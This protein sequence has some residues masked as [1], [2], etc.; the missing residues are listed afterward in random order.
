MKIILSLAIILLSLGCSRSVSDISKNIRY[1]GILN[2]ECELLHDGAIVDYSD[3]SND[4]PILIPKRDPLA[5]QHPGIYTF[6]TTVKKGTRIEIEKFV[7]ITSG[8]PPK[9]SSFNHA[10]GRIISESDV[11]WRDRKIQADDILSYMEHFTIFNQTFC[12]PIGDAAQTE[13]QL[14]EKV[15]SSVTGDDKTAKQVDALLI[16]AKQII[17]TS[18]SSNSNVA[19]IYETIGDLFSLR[20]MEMDRERAVKYWSEALAIYE[21]VLKEE[22]PQLSRALHRFASKTCRES[23]NK[24]QKALE[25]AL[26]LTERREGKS[27]KE[28][29]PLLESIID[30]SATRPTDKKSLELEPPY[31]FIP[32]QETFPQLR[33]LM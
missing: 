28:L 26:H 16:Q 31:F 11:S 15:T 21:R 12:N 9:T 3:G 14:M 30:C 1:S 7:H 32:P 20:H 23:N 2:K 25:R 6:R 33:R 22:D 19:E 18:G 24:S 10:Y 13:E 27:N 5:F 8:F 4:L 29:L 17:E